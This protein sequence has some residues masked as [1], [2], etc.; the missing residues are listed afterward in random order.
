MTYW[1]RI[2][3]KLMLISLLSEAAAPAAAAAAAPVPLPA[4]QLKVQVC[5]QLGVPSHCSPL[6]W[7]PSPH[8]GSLQFLL[9]ALGAK[10]ELA[11]PASHSSFPSTIP[12]PHL[13]VTS[14]KLTGLPFLAWRHL[15]LLERTRLNWA[16][17]HPE[18]G[19]GLAKTNQSAFSEQ[20]AEVNEPG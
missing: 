3:S 13:A 17:W 5:E 14:R 8:L 6:S 7:T 19:T 16:N 12:S 2:L 20:P 18:I 4:A 9:Q 1:A 11:G 15:L 10:S